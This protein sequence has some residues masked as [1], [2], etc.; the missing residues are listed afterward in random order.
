M[1]DWFDSGAVIGA[2]NGVAGWP[3]PLAWS[4]WAGFACH[5]TPEALIYTLSV[6]GFRR[7]DIEVE[8]R[9]RM[10]VVRGARFRRG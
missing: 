2:R 7:K 3:G 8:V 1:L 6:P 5:D 9:H 10:V 4:G